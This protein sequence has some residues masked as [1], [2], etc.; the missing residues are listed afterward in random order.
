MFEYFIV[1]ILMLCLDIRFACHG[2]SK[3]ERKKVKF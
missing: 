1:E 2:G 3:S